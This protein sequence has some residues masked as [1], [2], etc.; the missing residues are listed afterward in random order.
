MPFVNA[1][2]IKGQLYIPEEKP[3]RIRKHNCRDCASCMICNDDKCSL[4]LNREACVK[5]ARMFT[6]SDLDKYPHEI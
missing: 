6:N 2:G 4:C 5:N 1:P 3:G